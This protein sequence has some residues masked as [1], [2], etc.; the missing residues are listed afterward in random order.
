[1]VTKCNQLVLFG[2]ENSRDM[3]G[4]IGTNRDKYLSADAPQS[5]QF[6]PPP[7]KGGGQCPAG[8]GFGMSRVPCPGA[9]ALEKRNDENQADPAAAYPTKASIKAAFDAWTA[10]GQPWPPP[11]GLTSASASRLIPRRNR[12]ARTWRK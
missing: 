11:A 2:A 8:T 9:E 12:E 4:Q 3:P 6:G 5:G 10:E 7:L 1:M